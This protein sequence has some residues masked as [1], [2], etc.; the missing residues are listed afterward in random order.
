[1]NGSTATLMAGP[2]F[3]STSN[4]TLSAAFITV[5]GPVW[6]PLKSLNNSQFVVTIPG[7]VE[8]QSYIVLT[9]SMSGV[10]DDNIVAGP[11]IVEVV[12]M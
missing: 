11:A 6:A 7:G 8:G 1:M 3:N 9:S 4:S 10:S 2:G 12:S 5:T